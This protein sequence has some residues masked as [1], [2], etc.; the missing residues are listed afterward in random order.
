MCITDRIKIQCT[1]YLQTKPI[2]NNDLS[3]QMS[4]LLIYFIYIYIH[5]SIYIY[6]Y[7]SLSTYT[8][9]YLYLH[10]N[11][12]IMYVSI[13]SCIYIFT[14]TYLNIHIYCTS[15]YIY[16]FN[17]EFATKYPHHVSISTQMFLHSYSFL[18]LPLPLFHLSTNTTYVSYLKYNFSSKRNLTKM[19]QIKIK[20][21]GRHTS[22]QSIL[23]ITKKPIYL[24]SSIFQR[25]DFITRT[26]SQSVT[27]ME[28]HLKPSYHLI[29]QYLHLPYLLSQCYL[30]LC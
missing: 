21:K 18:S 10:I 29:Y 17:Y 15:L 3:I 5:I 28:H 9:T 12:Q 14:K 27:V 6:L 30:Q 7:I 16:I 22:N 1:N 24:K 19:V 8:H 2:I 11:I 23:Q 25:T 26:S 13:C 4:M 20:E